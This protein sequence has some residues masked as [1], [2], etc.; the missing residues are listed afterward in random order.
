MKIIKLEISKEEKVE[1]LEKFKKYCDEYKYDWVLE[2]LDEVKE[3]LGNM[4][5]SLCLNNLDD[6]EKIKNGRFLFSYNESFKELYKKLNK[7]WNATYNYLV[8][9]PNGWKYRLNQSEEII[10]KSL[11]SNC[12]KLVFVKGYQYIEPTIKQCEVIMNQLTEIM[13]NDFSLSSKIYL[14]R[15]E[16][17]KVYKRLLR[18]SKKELKKG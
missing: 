13:N 18:D 12:N 14:T 1:I 3:W 6:L 9:I 8:F 10:F 11:S 7:L 17:Y 2:V 16:V 4:D 15:K 5:E